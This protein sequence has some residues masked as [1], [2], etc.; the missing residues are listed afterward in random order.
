MPRKLAPVGPIFAQANTAVQEEVAHDGDSRFRLIAPNGVPVLLTVEELFDLTEVL[1]DMC[2]RI[3]G[4]GE[5]MT[6]Y[7]EYKGP[8]KINERVM[9]P[10]GPGTVGVLYPPTDFYEGKQVQ[11]TLDD[12]DPGPLY[13]QRTGEFVGMY[14]W[15]DGDYERFA[16]SDLTSLEG[17]RQ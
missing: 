10:K 11:V 1:D 7:I 14:D 12:A 15:Q 6:D 8:F 4:R 2:D 16:D 13:D 9:T 17:D 5:Q 3:E